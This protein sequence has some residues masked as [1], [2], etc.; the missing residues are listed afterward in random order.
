MMDSPVM[1]LT[2]EAEKRGWAA[3]SSLL[4]QAQLRKPVNVQMLFSNPLDEPVKNC[5]LM[6]EGSGLLLGSLKIDVPTLR[7]KERSRVRFE[8]LPT[9]SGTK[10]LVADFSC[11]KFP[12]IKAMLSVDVAE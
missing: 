12:A 8:I 10:Q 7:P 11:N 5:V 3:A 1:I 9:R 2:P 6:V 4:D